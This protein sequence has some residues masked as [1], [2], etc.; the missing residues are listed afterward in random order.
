MANTDLVPGPLSVDE[1]VGKV[2]HSVLMATN[3][4]WSIDD[5]RNKFQFGCE[6]GQRIVNGWLGALVRNPNYYGFR[7]TSG[8]VWLRW[9]AT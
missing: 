3:R 4:S 1:L 8:T 6:F 9:T 7:G 5:Y 2:E